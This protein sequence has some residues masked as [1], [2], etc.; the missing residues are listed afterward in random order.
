MTGRRSNQLNYAPRATDSVAGP[1]STA[2]SGVTTVDWI[3]VGRDRAR[4]PD[5]APARAHRRR[6]LGSPASSSARTSAP[7]SRPQF[8]SGTRVA[9]HAARRARRGGRAR[10]PVPEHRVDGRERD[11]DEPVRAAA[12]ARARL[13]RRARARRRRRAR[14][15]SG[16]LGAVALHL[17]GQREL[18][19]EV[20]QLADPRRDQ[21]A[22][23]AVAPARRDR[24]RRPVSRDPRARGER[25]AARSGAAGEP[26]GARRAQPS[27]FR[28]TGRPAASASQ[29]RAGSAAPNLVVTNAHVVAG[30]KDP[31]VDLR[32]GD[33]HDADVVAFDVRDDIAVLR[34]AGLGAPPLET[35]DPGRGPGRRDPRLPRERPLHRRARADR[36]DQQ[37]C[38]P[39]TPTGAAPSTARSRRCAGGS[40]TATRAA[41]RSTTAAACGRRSSPRAS[42]PTTR[43]T[44]C[45]RDI[46]QS[47]LAEAREAAAVSTGPCV[48]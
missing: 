15:S 48:G 44:A 2:V 38:S 6:P 3:A 5:R 32:D 35:V 14:R 34:V 11:P 31:R 30:M 29:A 26:G 24:A 39:R 10:D 22:R 20:Q 43:G 41:R 37:S 12:A 33:Y 25:R 8:L 4:G 46:V 7:S 28:V 23:A 9:V 21:R 47:T 36:P 40:G 16:S 27:V 19:E 13:A 45:R 17:P 18:R 42:A 1:L